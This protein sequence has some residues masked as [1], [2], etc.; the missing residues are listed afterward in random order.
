MRHSI[1]MLSA[2]DIINLNETANDMLYAILRGL[3]W[4]FDWYLRFSFVQTPHGFEGR[5]EFLEQKGENLQKADI[6]VF[7]FNF[8][9]PDGLSPFKSLELLRSEV[10]MLCT[11]MTQGRVSE[12]W[13]GLA[14]RL[15]VGGGN[16]IS[17]M[18]FKSPSTDVAVAS[19]N[20]K[21]NA[22]KC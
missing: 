1:V 9:A 3:N 12:D 5:A 6:R 7:R 15:L 22:A 8:R 10:A 14:Q 4:E 16:E 19:Y 21:T 17:M 20:A 13:G 18:F 11:A 2:D